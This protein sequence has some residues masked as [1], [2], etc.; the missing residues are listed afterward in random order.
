MEATIVSIKMGVINW[1]LK[2]SKISDVFQSAFE[3]HALFRR[4][5]LRHA[6]RSR[7]VLNFILTRDIEY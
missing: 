1:L 5:L 7:I 3:G 6:Q 2:M 4:R